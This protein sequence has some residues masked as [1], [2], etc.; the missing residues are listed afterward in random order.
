MLY[1]RYQVAID[2]PYFISD[3]TMMTKPVLYSFYRSSCARRVIAALHLKNIEY[4]YRAVNLLKGEQ[5]QSDFKVHNPQALVPALVIEGKTLTQS[6]SIIEYLDEV[7]PHHPLLPRDDPGRRADV[8]KLALMIAADIQPLQN[9]RVLK[10]VGKE[11]RMAYG[12][13]VIE[14]GFAALEEELIKTAGIYCYR[15]SITVP[16]LCLVPQVFNA[17]SFGVDLTQFPT[18]SRI[19]R[20]LSKHDAFIKAHPSQQPDYPH[21]QK[22]S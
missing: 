6:L 9:L 20:E 1:H 13:W 4:E 17:Q 22:I 15:D 7:Y 21:E 16:D 12:K 19:E 14:N 3:D 10:Y 5:Q 8:R 11:K 18:I 2:K